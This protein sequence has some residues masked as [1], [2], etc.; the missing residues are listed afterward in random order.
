MYI[1]IVN[2]I[3]IIIGVRSEVQGLKHPHFQKIQINPQIM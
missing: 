2:F 3:A 1:P